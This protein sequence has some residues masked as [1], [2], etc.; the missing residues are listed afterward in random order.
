MQGL[1]FVYGQS[2]LCEAFDVWAGLDVCGTELY[3]SRTKD[4]NY[5]S[6]D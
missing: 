1:C 4:D 5:S 3:N 2:C 6:E